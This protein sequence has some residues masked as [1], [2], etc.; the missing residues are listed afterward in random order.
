VALN[1][2]PITTS[3]KIFQKRPSDTEQ[4]H[5]SRMLYSR[6]FLTI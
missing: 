5:M 4:S 6:C 3:I 2:R 1:L